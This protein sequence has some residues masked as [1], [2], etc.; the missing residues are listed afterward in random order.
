MGTSARAA[1]LPGGARRAAARPRGRAGAPGR[2]RSPPA[3]WTCST[4][5]AE[6]AGWREASPRSGETPDAF[7]ADAAVAPGCGQ[8]KA[9]A[10]ARG[11]RVAKC[12]R[13]LR[14]E[15]ELGARAR[16]PG[17]QAHRPREG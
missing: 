1:G 10:P 15:E 2:A 14:I 16:F 5:E 9:G 4:R 7:L 17:P 3:A 8:V 13:L 11:E 12:N 6:R